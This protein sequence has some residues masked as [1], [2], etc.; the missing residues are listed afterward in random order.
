MLCSSPKPHPQRLEMCWFFVCYFCLFFF[1]VWRRHPNLQKKQKKGTCH[2]VEHKKP[3]SKYMIVCILSFN[4]TD[5]WGWG[6]LKSRGQRRGVESPSVTPADVLREGDH[7][8]SWRAVKSHL[9]ECVTVG[10]ACNT[11]WRWRDFTVSEK[12]AGNIILSSRSGYSPRQAAPVTLHMS[13]P[14]T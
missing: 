2:R 14:P 6:G 3:R 1:L 13:Y 5:V 11:Q 9:C 7:W 12:C 8:Y 4:G 10:A